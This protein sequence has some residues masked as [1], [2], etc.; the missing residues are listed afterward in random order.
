MLKSP[1]ILG[2]ASPEPPLIQAIGPANS[3]AAEFTQNDPT[4]EDTPAVRVSRVLYVF[5]EV[6]QKS[7]LG[8]HL[9]EL[10]SL[11]DFALKCHETDL[12]RKPTHNVL[13][14]MFR[15]PLVAK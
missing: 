15:K 1:T 14:N 6:R 4:N 7:D 2:H 8:S 13:E 9:Q 3:E 10:A 12:Y 5:A 11:G